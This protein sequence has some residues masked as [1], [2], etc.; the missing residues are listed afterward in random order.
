MRRNPDLADTDLAV[1]AAVTI[2]A[3]LVTGLIG[4]GGPAIA[5]LRVLAGMLLVLVL[6]GYA[7]TAFIQPARSPRRFSPV[8]WRGMCSVGLSMAVAALGGLVLNL[9][10]AGL[11]RVSWT[12]LLA[13]VTL[14]ALA[15]AVWL[16]PDS[17]R[18]TDSRRAK[19]SWHSW[20]Q[21]WAVAG[22]SL[23]ALALAG[24]AT[25]L[26]VVSGGWQHSPSFAQLWLV[27]GSAKATL[28]VRSGYPDAREFRLVLK[29]GTRQAGTWDF[30]LTAGQTWQRTVAEPAGQR[31]TA[32]LT[33]AGQ[34]QSQTVAITSGGT[35]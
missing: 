4:G 14:L 23:G 25:G 31:L 33:A 6:P 7:L 30:T 12:I 17:R 15:A 16:R 24:A 26:A 32:Q 18:S 8:L 13:A 21:T 34:T 22:Y 20:R 10:P 19:H 11:T 1:T 2:V 29:N 27:P 9:I 35:A 5:W 28:G 3:S